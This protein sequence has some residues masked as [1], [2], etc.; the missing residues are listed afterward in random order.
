MK[1]QKISFIFLL[2]F[3]SLNIFASSEEANPFRKVAREVTPTV[4]KIDTVFKTKVPTVNSLFEYFFRDGNS[5]N[6]ED[7]YIERESRG[8]GSGIVVESRGNKKYVITNNHVIDGADSFTIQFTNGNSYDAT[9]VG[10]DSRKDLALLMFET[11][12]NI[13][14]AKLGDSNDLYIGDWAIAI[15]SPL[16]YEA[17]VTAG[18]ISAIGRPSAPGL[19]ADFTDYIQTDAAINRGNSG[20]ALVNI[21]GEIIGINTWI[22]SQTGGNIGLGFAIPINNAKDTINQLIDTGMVKYGWLG[23]T[24]GSVT[25][26]LKNEMGLKST[27]GAFIHNVFINAPA[28]KDGLIPGDVV[29]RAG[30]QSIKT[31]KELL[32]IVGNLSAGK[33]V[34]FT[35][36]R[37][38]KE[39][40]LNIT[41]VIR[42]KEL[43]TA[44]MWTGINPVTL[45]KDIID[46]YNQRAQNKLSA[47]TKG[48][49]VAQVAENSVA[50][51][52]GLLP[53]DIITHIEGKRVSNIKDYYNAL[54]NTSKELTLSVIRN[55]NNIRVILLKD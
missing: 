51:I 41:P 54:N 18:I 26:T 4:V 43:E 28:E 12:D 22:A 31:D 40:T 37:D 15:G 45:T 1:N 38:G 35:V 21:D 10:T 11:R 50:K 34:Q 3:L 36:I 33:V 30:N 6:S 5:N 47:L 23:V 13:P 25:E 14:V 2:L 48:V 7:N 19:G 29:I 27:D 17:S 16:G 46:A 52:T 9:L 55:N 53:G 39:V 49:V 32:K 42:S 44:K 20:G 8:L 24:I